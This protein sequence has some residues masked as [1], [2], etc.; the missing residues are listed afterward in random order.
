MSKNEKIGGLGKHT[1]FKVRI[2]S[3]DTPMCPPTYT[4]TYTS[5][6]YADVYI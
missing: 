5:N 6:G 3:T 4:P 2:R 1:F